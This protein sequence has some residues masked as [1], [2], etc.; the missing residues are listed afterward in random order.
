MSSGY[1][2]YKSGTDAYR[3]DV[4]AVILVPLADSAASDGFTHIAEHGNS[5]RW[6][7][8]AASGGEPRI[9]VATF[10]IG[11]NWYGLPAMSIE[12]CID[13]T[14]LIR[15][16][17]VA[18]KVA[19]MTVYGEDSIPVYDL[20]DLRGATDCA[21]GTRQIILLRASPVSDPFGI[22]IDGLGE[23]P[24]VPR[25]ALQPV[26]MLGD[27]ISALLDGLLMPIPVDADAGAPMLML[28]SL[29]RLCERLHR[30]PAG[31]TVQAAA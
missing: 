1:R 13:T 19:G 21:S 16:P 25:S 18:S 10:Y 28:L 14:R 31:G 3:N 8:P 7:W 17:G 4:A 9:E 24:E 30:T 27:D 20:A 29:D 22:V 23:I 2:E 5:R 11:E 26:P 6:S 15:V 12:A